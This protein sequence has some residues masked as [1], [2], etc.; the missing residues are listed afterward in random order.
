M[1]KEN[2][3]SRKTITV[4]SSNFWEFLENINEESQERLEDN[5]ILLK[6]ETYVKE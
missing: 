5:S 4:N 6:F 1:K 3:S 2:C